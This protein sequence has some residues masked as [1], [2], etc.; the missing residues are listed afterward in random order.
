[1]ATIQVLVEEQSLQQHQVWYNIEEASLQAL[2]TIRY[3][4][5]YDHLYHFL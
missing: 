2:E 3:N 5:E 4:T 1:M